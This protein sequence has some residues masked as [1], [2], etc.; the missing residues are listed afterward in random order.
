MKMVAATEVRRPEVSR[1]VDYLHEFVN[2]TTYKIF[3]EVQGCNAKID[4]DALGFDWSTKGDRIT[5]GKWRKERESIQFLQ[6]ILQHGYPALESVSSLDEAL[7]FGF[8]IYQC[9]RYWHSR[10]R[11]QHRR[12]DIG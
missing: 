7:D 3:H 12:G 9:G 4:E 10:T 11:V 2:S 6:S 5:M 1:S 8:D